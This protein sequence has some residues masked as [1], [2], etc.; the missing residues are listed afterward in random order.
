M[1]WVWPDL[2]VHILIGWLPLNIRTRQT[3]YNWSQAPTP[4]LWGHPWEKLRGHRSRRWLFGFQFYV[5]HHKPKPANSVTLEHLEMVSKSKWDE[6]LDKMMPSG[7]D[8]NAK[9]TLIGPDLVLMLLDDLT[10]CHRQLPQHKSYFWSKLWV[11]PL[12]PFY[13]NYWTPKSTAN[14]NM[15][16]SNYFLDNG[17]D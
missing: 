10:N 6:D 16:F 13:G 14:L 7:K 15:I 12:L 5:I 17:S 8:E 4:A 11:F 2:A 3:L 1:A 9:S